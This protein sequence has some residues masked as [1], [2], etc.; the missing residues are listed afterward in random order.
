MTIMKKLAVHS[1]VAQMQI[2]DFGDGPEVIKLSSCSTQLSIKL[3][4]FTS[5][6]MRTIVGC[7]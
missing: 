2:A 5:V 1:T 3:I 4:M 7:E 6:E